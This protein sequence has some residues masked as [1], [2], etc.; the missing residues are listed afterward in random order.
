MAVTVIVK[1]G[2]CLSSIAF[3]RGHFWPT[4]W[5]DPANA[6]LK[7]ERKNAHVLRA[8]DAVFVPDIRP[9]EVQAATG[10]RH[11]FRR[12]G[13]PEQLR[14]RFGSA[15]NPRAGV[16]YELTIDGVTVAGKTS[17]AGE[18]TSYLAPNAR[19]GELVLRPEGAPEERYVLALRELDPIDTLRGA[20][21]RLRNLG[22]PPGEMDEAAT[23]EFVAAMNDFQAA[24]KLPK[25]DAI[26][27]ATRDA[28]LAAHGT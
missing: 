18:V 24:A 21:Q 26:D 28:L 7:A 3:E 19:E 10:R 20:K 16:P 12:K 2:E 1:A 15:S 23:P 6:A 5:D 13:V 8:G 17:S 9:K 14:I 25:T 4:I 27:A 11:T 22:Y